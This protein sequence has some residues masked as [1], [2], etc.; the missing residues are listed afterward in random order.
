MWKTIPGFPD[1]YEVSDEGKVRTWLVR[2]S[3]NMAERPSEMIGWEMRGYPTVLLRDTSG[4]RRC[5]RVH[6]AV[7][8]AFVGPCP[9]GHEARHLDGSRNN[10]RLDNL[11]WGTPKE[12]SDDK[13]R[14]GTMIVGEM[15][16][17][18]KLQS[19]DVV[20]IRSLLRRG[21]GIQFVASLF[22][23]SK[24]M[25]ARIRDGISWVDVSDRAQ[26]IEQANECPA[27][28]GCLL[29]L[30]REAWGDQGLHCA[31]RYSDG[32]WLWHVQGGHPHGA[33]FRRRVY[34]I[35]HGT[36]AEALVAALEAAPC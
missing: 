15:C 22:G 27:T 24:R 16:V 5:V 2:G 31:G 14:H 20:A 12:N 8:L 29:A 33:T 11:K 13:R 36:E 32:K 18:A 23:V 10:N 21:H 34:A 19:A 28:L 35:G 17:T 3:K 6:S 26:L 7:L 30:V 9:P 1:H 25:V 4:S